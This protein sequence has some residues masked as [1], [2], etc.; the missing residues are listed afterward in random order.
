MIGRC[1]VRPQSSLRHSK[2]FFA[3]LVELRLDFRKGGAMLGALFLSVKHA[4][5]RVILLNANG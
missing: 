2:R 4:Y 3:L 5:L 1:I